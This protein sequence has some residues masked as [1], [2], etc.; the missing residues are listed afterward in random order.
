MHLT[1]TSQE[2][3][4]QLLAPLKRHQLISFAMHKKCREGDFVVPAAAQLLGICLVSGHEAAELRTQQSLQSALRAQGEALR[5]IN[6]WILPAK[7]RLPYAP[8]SIG[9]GLLYCTCSLSASQLNAWRAE[10]SNLEGCSHDYACLTYQDGKLQTAL[11]ATPLQLGQEKRCCHR[12][13]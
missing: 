6:F 9:I 13:L 2:A 11:C 12:A 7:P 8:S 10:Q 5:N 4:R 3:G 1:A